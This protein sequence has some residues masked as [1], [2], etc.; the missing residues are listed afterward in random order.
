MVSD[1]FINFI[2]NIMDINNIFLQRVSGKIIS[3][4]VNY[5][6]TFFFFFDC[7]AWHMG[8]LVP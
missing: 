7:T 4:P 5:S 6:C 8:I 1:V 3:H 2:N